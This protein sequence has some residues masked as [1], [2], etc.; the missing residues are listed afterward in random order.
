[1]EHCPVQG[2]RDERGTEA[3][4]DLEANRVPGGF[5]L[6]R[7]QDPIWVFGRRGG[8]LW[9]GKGALKVALEVDRSAGL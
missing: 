6:D 4:A 7:I 3:E 2:H 1:M 8:P 5:E 9:R